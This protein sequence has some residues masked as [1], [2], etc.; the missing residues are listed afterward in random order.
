[1]VQRV[2]PVRIQTK[3]SPISSHTCPPTSELVGSE[4]SRVNC[5]SRVLHSNFGVP[6]IVD[7]I[8]ARKEYFSLPSCVIYMHEQRE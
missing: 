5:L 6:L 8:L 1:M 2:D 3:Y 4:C 7:I